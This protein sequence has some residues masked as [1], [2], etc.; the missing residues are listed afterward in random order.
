M[1]MAP[2]ARGGAD[3]LASGL[4]ELQTPSAEALS[5]L[6]VAWQ[7]VQ[8]RH[9][10]PWQG[11]R[12]PYRVWLSEVMLQQTQVATVLG[13]FPRFLER[14]PDVR[15]LAEAELDEVLGLWSGLG[16]YSRA[17]NL[18]RCAR[19]VVERHG[20]VFPSSAAGLVEL[21]GIGPSTAAAIAAFCHPGRQCQA[22]AEPGAGFSGRPLR[23]SPRAAIAPSGTGPPALRGVADA[24]LH[25]GIDGL[26]GHRLPA[27][28]AALRSLSLVR[29]LPWFVARACPGLSVAHAQTQA[30]VTAGLV[31]LAGGSTAR[32]RVAATTP[33]PWHLV[34]AVVLAPLFRRSSLPG[35]VSRRAAGNAVAVVA[36]LPACADPSGLDPAPAAT[37]PVRSGAGS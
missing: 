31:P 6:L 33:G 8:G 21:P 23:G 17:R 10:L 7:R 25:P 12:D 28:P 27:S 22:R 30:Q 19:Q 37:E 3:A 1:T 29:S 34:R 13:Y 36:R 35:G 4:D 2:G 14:F 24:S 15:A 9:D 20:G 18:H 11:T 16:Y 32:R 5:D 26:G